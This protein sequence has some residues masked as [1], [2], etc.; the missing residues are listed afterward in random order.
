MAENKLPIEGTEQDNLCLRTTDE[1]ESQVD[2]SYI[3][4]KIALRADITTDDECEW[5]GSDNTEL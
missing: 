4:E 2:F 5:G 3:F 1:V